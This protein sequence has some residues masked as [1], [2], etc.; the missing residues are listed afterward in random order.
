MHD[1]SLEIKPGE[2]VALVGPSGA[3]KS[4]IAGLIP[5]FYDPTEGTVEIDGHDLRTVTLESLRSQV[6]LVSQ[7]TVL[8]RVS[9]AENI[10]AGRKGFTRKD[11]EEAA[12]LANAH[13][14]IMELPNGYDT[15]IGEGGATLSG[16]QRQRIAIARALLGNPRILV[17]DEATSNLDAES[18]QL[19]QEALDRLSQ[20]RTTIVIAHRAA[21]VQ[22][23]DRVVVVNKGRIVQ[24]G[25]HHELSAKTD[26]TGGCSAPW[27]SRT[28]T[29]RAPRCRVEGGGSV[30]IRVEGLVKRYG[31]RKVV[32]GVSLHVE[33]GEVV[34]LPRAE[35]RGEDDHFLHDRRARAAE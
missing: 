5:R 12:R 19:V 27:P 7:D 28:W 15:V 2:T 11:I 29:F 33:R 13:D 30:S 10:T 3:G 24:Q 22:A 25:K 26:C 34:G 9:I 35:R 14:F 31:G 16:G 18:E 21:T 8:F 32:D 4:T 1:V 20:G 17:L 6:G 23:A